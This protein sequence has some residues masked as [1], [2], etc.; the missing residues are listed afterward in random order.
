MYERTCSVEKQWTFHHQVVQ[1]ICRWW[2]TPQVDLFASSLCIPE[3]EVDALSLSWKNPI[4]PNRKSTRKDSMRT[5]RDNSY[6]SIVALAP[7]VSDTPPLSHL[8]SS[9]TV[10][11]K[12][13]TL[14]AK[15]TNRARRFRQI[16]LARL[17]SSIEQALMKRGFSRGIVQR[18]GMSRWSS[19]NKVYEHRWARY[20]DYCKQ[21]NMDQFRPSVT[22]LWSNYTD[23]RLLLHCANVAI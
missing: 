22:K 16:K 11:A 7:M 12:R 9:V 6:C 13:P 5:M 23:L 2:L 21:R 14:A 1:T 17:T 20:M 8:S 3:S 10:T 15:L 19:T 4:F 18:V